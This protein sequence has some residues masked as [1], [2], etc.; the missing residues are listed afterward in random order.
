MTCKTAQFFR[1]KHTLAVLAALTTSFSVYA[2]ENNDEKRKNRDED[3][4]KVLITAERRSVSE[5]DM[6]MSVIGFSGEAL[7]NKNITDMERLQAQVPNLVFTDNGNTKYINIRG[8]GISESA[9][10][11]TNGVAVHL[12][13]AY[14]AREFVY[15]DAF[16]DLGS[17]EVLRG[18]QGTYSGQNAS[19]GAI[20]INSKKP[21]LGETEGFAAAEKGSYNLTKYSG[22][23]TFPLSDNL[24]MRISGNVESR[25]SF[26]TNHGPDPDTDASLVKDQPGNLDRS[27]GRY[28]LLYS[29]DDNLEMRL[30]Y[31]ESRN[32]SD[33]VA[34]KRFPEKGNTRLPETGVWDLNYDLDGHRSVRYNR[35]TFT[36]DWQFSEGVKLLTNF[37][38]F[39]STQ[40]I[41]TDGDY[42][43]YLTITDEPQT[44]RDFRIFDEYWTGEMTL[45]STGE[46]PFQWTTGL[47]IIDYDQKNN[48]NLLRY[49]NESYPRTSLDL[50]S[51]TRLFMYLHNVRKNKAV[52]G[53]VA[54][55]FTPDVEVKFGLRYNRDEVGFAEDSYITP[56]AGSYNATSGRPFPQNQLFDFSALTGRVVANWHLS[57][58]SMLYGTIGRGYKPGGTSPFGPD[59]DSEYVLNK[60]I[61][62][63]GGVFDDQTQLSVSVFHMDYDNF[64]RTFA[65]PDSPQE[66]VTRN[67]DGSTIAGIEAQLSGIHADIRWDISMAFNKGEYG[68]LEYVLPAGAYDG[69]NPATDL[70]L[71]LS[72]ESIDFLPERSLSWGLEYLGWETESGVILPSLRMSYQSEFY[73]SFFHLD[74]QLTP[75]R[76]IWE[77]NVAY[78]SD[79]GWRADLYVQNLTDETYISRATGDTDGVGVYNLGAPRQ[80]GVKVRYNF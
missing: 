50:E 36:T 46:G 28:Q 2:Q 41:R 8:V 30:I 4:E 15:G 10:N 14:V 60:E 47:S 80:V 55:Q 17:I 64:Q 78:E 69:E 6:P 12:D 57:D 51:H 5:S 45:V 66:S 33:G 22:G 42:G 53:E 54:Y 59:Y 72:G 35:T 39:D 1:T 63:K 31:E 68:D 65:P 62:W 32:E 37:S 19:G 49:N 48:L 27:M 20:F 74:H 52:F 77:A 67:V 76:T 75:S 44:G 18:P 40:D 24:A 34:T 16:F 73:T 70:S 7:E 23:L 9:P 61:G 3:I 13:G 38:Y 71:N 21:V 25:D 11:Q 56:G 29:P 26:F 43:S 58:D 79:S